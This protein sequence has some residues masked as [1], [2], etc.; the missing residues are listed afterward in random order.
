MSSEP[1]TNGEVL[2]VYEVWLNSYLTG[3]VKTYDQYLDDEYR[4]IGSTANE[5][6]LSRKETTKFFEATSDQLAGK[7]DVR[8]STRTVQQ[9]G[10]LVFI[11]QLLDAWFLK[12]TDWFYYGRFRFTSV[13]RKRENEWKFI[14]QHFSTP[15]SKADAGDTIGYDKVNKENVELRD[16]IKRRTIEIEH[17]SRELEIEAALERV[18]S[19]SMEMRNSEELAEVIQVV[20]RQ[21]LRLKIPVDHAGFIL[22][23][24]ERDDMHIW[25][26]DHQQGVPSEITIPYFDS[27]HWNSFVEA[28]SK[29]E[30]FFA[31]L[32]DFEE[33]NKFYNDLMGLIPSM[34]EE[35]IQNIFGKRGLT[36]STVLLDNVG[37]YIENYSGTPFTDEENA[38]LMRFGK[39][40]QQAYTR[41]LDLQKA[42]S[43]A[44][45]GKIQLALERVRMVALG[46]S[47]SEQML[48]VAK[49][50]YEQLLELGFTNMR[51]A[52]IDINNEDGDT[53][54]DYDY[55]HEMSGTITQM[56]YYDDPTLQGQFQKMSTTTD[57]FFELV[58]EGEELEDLINMRIKNGE[59]E[60]VRLLNI[61]QLTYNLF[62]FGN[63]AIGIS[64]FG[65]L[66][67]EEKAI[68]D[69]FRNVFT[70]AYKRYND[71]ASAE[72][73]AREVQIE[74]SLERI[75]AQVTGMQESTDLLDI[76]VAMRS[77]FV[78]LGYE[79]H[80]FWHMHWLPYT[81]K[82]AMTSGDGAKIGMVMTLP[83]HIHGDIPTVANWEKSKEPIFVLAMDVDVAVDYIDKMITL[84]D[85]EL[86]DPQAPSL[87]DIRH[88]GGLTFVMA[89]TTHGEIGFSLPGVVPNPPKEAVD[90]LVRFAGVFDLAYKR[91]E[92]LKTA[93][94][95]LIEIKKARQKAESALTE[96]KA[97][98]AQLVQQEKLASLGQLTAGIAHE[99]KNPLNFVNNFSEV[100]VE[101]IDEALEELGSL[102]DSDTKEEITAILNSVKGN[103]TKVNEHG[104]RADSIIKSMLQH[105]RGGSG[106]MESTDLNKLVK[107]YT[108]LAFHVMRAGKNPINAEIDL[109]LDPKIKAVPMIGED[110]SRVV[111]NLT[112]NAFDAMR[113]TA[114][115][116]PPKLSVRTILDSK[117]I[118]IELEDNG[119]GIADD[120]IDK[121][122]QPFF[123]TK[124]GTEGTGLGLSITNDIIKAHGGQLNIQ[125]IPGKTIFQ[126]HLT[127]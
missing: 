8:N 41:F 38:T 120:I 36:I 87:D 22:D 117:S 3:D 29:G 15:D 90:T 43:Q 100:S 37:L 79:A 23:Y 34:P 13:L 45:E 68:L 46:L 58:L 33:K 77:E 108:N 114:N 27:P 16:A 127:L 62:S 39:V 85:F 70:F 125:S 76:V 106:K 88:I 111:L 122:L 82:K 28:K 66:S 126:I 65:I 19:R 44:R 12:E 121:I 21:F 50:L 7:T 53:F 59:D 123:T 107:E 83:R 95:D 84:G 67:T 26:A 73:Q 47:R 20:Y 109:Q 69:R 102:E 57:D 98:Q 2:E 18:R 52:I 49:S 5:E 81:Y 105:S 63:G 54:T 86:V 61:D 64:N 124:K 99:I 14:Y 113:E 71:L 101:L 93:E 17:K 40:F 118:H 4:F 56:S 94:K 9:M 32:L 11:T 1:T 75:R 72:A 10:D 115:T 60:D 104:S 103:L 51:N 25:L 30:N 89:R 48:E 31:N 24:K 35:T 112:N 97:T 80:Y 96:L 6:F 110:I 74:L 42:E 116:R 78:N 91:F 92:D 119:P 55:S